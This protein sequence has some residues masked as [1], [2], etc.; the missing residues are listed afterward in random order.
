MPDQDFLGVGWKTPLQINARGGIAKTGG[1]QK[2]KESIITILGTAEGERV[3]RPTFGS[4]LHTL[5]FEPNNQ[6]TLELARHYATEALTL[7][8]PRIEVS[9]VIVKSEPGHGR[10]L[11]EVAYRIRDTNSPQNLVYP[12]YLK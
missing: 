11:I 3:M 9:N 1:E 5:V 8:E 4:K 12:F 10:I 7:W 2:I 6:I